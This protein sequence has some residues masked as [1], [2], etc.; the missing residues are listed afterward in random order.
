[1]K[2]VN[3]LFKAKKLSVN[4]SKTNIM[5]LGTPHMTSEKT[6]DKSN[7]LLNDTILERV[8]VTKF[9]VVLI[10]ECLT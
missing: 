6:R 3:D 7:V 4:A 8:R 5:F 10:D 9:L 1:M 2:K